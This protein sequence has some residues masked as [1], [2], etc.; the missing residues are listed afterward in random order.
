MTFHRSHA[1][2]TLLIASFVVLTGCGG[3]KDEPKPR[4]A[5]H[6]PRAE[7]LAVMRQYDAQ[8]LYDDELS[9]GEVGALG[10]DFR[11]IE[12]LEIADSGGDRSAP[13]MVEA[14]KKLFGDAT[15]RPTGYLF[16]RIK[17]IASAKQKL[18]S[19]ERPGPDTVAQNLS[20]A[21]WLGYMLDRRKSGEDPGAIPDQRE[22]D[23]S[24]HL[25]SSRMGFVQLGDPYS[26]VDN[27]IFRIATLIHE[28]RHSDCPNGIT[29]S[30]L[31]QFLDPQSKPSN[32]DI[33]SVIG[34]CGF[35]H[36]DCPAGHPLAG[37]P[38]CE[39]GEGWGAYSVMIPFNR[40]IYRQCTN[41]SEDDRQAAAVSASEAATRII[42]VDDLLDGRLG[43]PNMEQRGYR[44]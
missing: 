3:K 16:E 10:Y 32:D 13:V 14:Y 6:L 5:T 31:D 11:K 30:Q 29:G 7:G 1:L 34:T 39:D 2:A 12:G 36:P 43:A 35:L 4:L 19:G 26:A 18:V 37:K 8:F 20:V 27:S 38:A 41:C 25:N 22:G 15:A 33:I 23:R 44:N 40:M 17:L 21:F 9:D 42:R 28:A 24:I